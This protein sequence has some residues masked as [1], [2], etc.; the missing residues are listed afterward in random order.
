VVGIKVLS[1]GLYVA[2]ARHAF[3]ASSSWIWVERGWSADPRFPVFTATRQEFIQA[4]IDRWLPTVF[5]WEAASEIDTLQLTWV[6]TIPTSI[7]KNGAII[8]RDQIDVHYRRSYFA[9][10]HKQTTNASEQD[11]SLPVLKPTNR[12]WT[13]ALKKPFPMAV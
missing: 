2:V 13:S 7:W 8:R 12:R 5:G 11:Q 9:R 3:G 10:S 1:V 4:G 6:V